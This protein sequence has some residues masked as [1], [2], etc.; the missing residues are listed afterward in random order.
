VQFQN[1]VST[2]YVLSKAWK[3]N[4]NYVLY[5]PMYSFSDDVSLTA[6]EGVRV[7]CPSAGV[8]AVTHSE[9]QKD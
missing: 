2:P 9:W 8:P 1:S 7:T 6:I 5:I 4:I 3:C